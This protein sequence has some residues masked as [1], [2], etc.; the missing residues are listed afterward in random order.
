MS[1]NMNKL[2]WESVPDQKR[3]NEL[4]SKLFEVTQPSAVFSEPVVAGEYTVITASEVTVAMGTGYGGGGG[5]APSVSKPEEDT[6]QEAN[7]GAG[8][9]GGGGGTALARPVA[10][11]SVGPG[12][13]VVE[14][15]VDPTKIALAFFTAIGGMVMALRKMRRA[16]A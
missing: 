4:V 12:G 10:V 5:S 7:V 6:T 16:S 3:A 13:V 9:G 8:G 14:P 15:V 1:E 2:F 11:I